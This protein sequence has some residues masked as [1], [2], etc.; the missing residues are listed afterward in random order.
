M[1][2]QVKKISNQYEKSD[3]VFY[4]E[5]AFINPNRL[6]KIYVDSVIDITANKDTRMIITSV[7][8][9][10][11]MFMHLV[12]NSERKENDPLKNIF[13][14]TRTYWWEVEG[15]DEQWK[16]DRIN[17]MGGNIDWFNQEYDLRFISK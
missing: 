10:M 14:T 7:P 16:Q 5:F 15:R 17:D 6:N 8:N 1:G 2:S 4:L 12:Q 3:I 13:I 9:A 11:N